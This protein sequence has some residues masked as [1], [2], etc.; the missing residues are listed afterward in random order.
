M[1]PEIFYAGDKI[2]A[3]RA[4]GLPETGPLIGSAGALTRNRDIAILYRAFERVKS[5][6]PRVHLR[7][8]FV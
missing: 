5:I 2:T 7:N 8:N 6:E 1:A 4:L 3:R